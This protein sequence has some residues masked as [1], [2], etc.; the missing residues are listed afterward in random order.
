MVNPTSPTCLKGSPWVSEMAL[1]LL[2]GQLQN[3]LISV[4][5]DDN[6]HPAAEIHPYH[7]PQI[8]GEC[9]IDTTEAC[10]IK[11]YSVTQ[12]AYNP[13]DE[14]DTGKQAIAA[15]EMRVKMKSS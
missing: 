15:Y 3:E 2:I 9:A 11:H 14:K 12:N 7:H 5:N 4:L 8:E 10:I 6:F 13:L 1:P